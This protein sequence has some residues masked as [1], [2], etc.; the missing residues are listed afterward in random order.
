[1]PRTSVA[2]LRLIIE[3]ALGDAELEAYIDDASAWVDAHLAS[4]CPALTAAGLER[5]ERYLAAAL[6]TRR[7]P[8]LV[9]AR[10]EDVQE[11]YAV[12]KDGLHWFRVA[13]AFDPCGIVAREFLD[14]KRLKFRVGTRFQDEAHG[15]GRPP[16]WGA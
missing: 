10:R 13:A 6:V 5:V 12:D 4:T 1:M 14:A 15:G 8:A 16:S 7:E 3:T 2:A 11:A 9:Q